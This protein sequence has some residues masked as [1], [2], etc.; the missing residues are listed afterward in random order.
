MNPVT[1]FLKH[2]KL[3]AGAKWLLRSKNDSEKNM[4]T[5]ADLKKD[6]GI[7]DLNPLLDEL[8]GSGM[9]AAREVSGRV[10]Y[11]ISDHFLQHRIAA[12]RNGI[13]SVGD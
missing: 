5:L 6:S 7:E 4:H 11:F 8:I 13:E 10:Y 9:L 12:E 2:K 3:S 1:E